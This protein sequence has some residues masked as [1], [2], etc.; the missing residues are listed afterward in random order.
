[1]GVGVEEDSDEETFLSLFNLR[2][3]KEC[4][5][6]SYTLDQAGPEPTATISLDGTTVAVAVEAKIEIFPVPQRCF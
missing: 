4:S 5:I 2:S 1:L 3:G 6:K